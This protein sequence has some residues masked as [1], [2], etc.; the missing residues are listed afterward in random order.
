MSASTFLDHELLLKFI[1]LSL[2]KFKN[3]KY[4]LNFRYGFSLDKLE[5]EVVKRSFKEISNISIEGAWITL[6]LYY[7]IIF[8][9]KTKWHFFKDEVKNILLI[10]N[11]LYINEYLDMMEYEWSELVIKILNNGRNIDFAIHITREIVKFCSGNI[12]KFNYEMYFQNIF[13]YLIAH[14]F[15]CIWLELSKGILSDDVTYFNLMHIIGARIDFNDNFEE[16]MRNNLEEKNGLLFKNKNDLI[17]EWCHNNKPIAPIRIARYIP[18]FSN[19]KRDSWHPF[20]LK[21]I[22]EFGNDEK[23]L[24]E[25]SAN[26]GTYSWT[27]S[28]VP[29]LIAEKK[30]Y[31]ILSTNKNIAVQNWAKKNIHYIEENIK[32]QRIWDDELYL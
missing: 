7:N 8:R 29:L 32:K 15:E 14:Y 23:V 9:E 11:L 12:Y 5:N 21:F 16:S 2:N 1:D 27:G 30:L 18:I 20:A 31:E 4:L 6:I 17:I 19:N 22:D 13:K 3:L 10:P 24:I 28:V 25:I 26:M